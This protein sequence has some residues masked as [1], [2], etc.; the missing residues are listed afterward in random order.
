MAKEY[1]VVW[2]EV[3]KLLS[4]GHRRAEEQQRLCNEKAADGCRLVAVG[5]YLYFEREAQG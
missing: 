4:S 5:T 1:S 2:P 3:T